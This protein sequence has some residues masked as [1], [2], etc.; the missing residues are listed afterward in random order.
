DAHGLLD[1][2]LDLL[3]DAVTHASRLLG[4]GVDDRDVRHVDRGLDGLDA[5]GLGAAL[6]LTDAVVLGD[7]LDALND[8]AVAED[9]QD[10]ALLAT[11][12][13]A[14]LRS[15]G[16]DLNQV[17]LLD[18]GHELQHLRGERHDLHEL[19][20][21][22]LAAD[23]SEDTRATGLAVVVQD[24]GRVL[25]ELDVRAIFTTRLLDGADDDR[26]DDVALLHV[27]AGDRVLDRR[28]DGVTHARATAVCAPED[29]DRAQPLRAGVAGVGAAAFL[30]D[31]VLVRLV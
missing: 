1:A 2:V 23:R 29:A 9:S 12:A 11:V 4:L 24:D 13:A 28:D 5:T 3:L 30:L 7:V 27:A 10:L 22:K 8:H 26:L 21:A 14:L 15:A 18:L 31:D 6:R 16:D 17:T 20:V 19:A 25:I